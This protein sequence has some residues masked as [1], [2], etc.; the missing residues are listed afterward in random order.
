[1]RLGAGP[2]GRNNH[3]KGYESRTSETC[4]SMTASAPC[5]LHDLVAGLCSDIF[6]TDGGKL[7]QKWDL[8]EFVR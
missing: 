5:Y 3:V 1:M 8:K 4:L 7:S 2:D 6:A